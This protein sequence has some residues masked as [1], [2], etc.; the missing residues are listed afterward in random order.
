MK[1][2]TNTTP[3]ISLAAIGKF[4]LFQQL[5]ETII[6]PQA[7]HDEIKVKQSFAYKEIDADWVQVK[8]VE[9]E[10]Y[11]Q[12]LRNDLDQGEAE[13]ICL[14]K[15]IAADALIIDERMGYKIAQSQGFFV[16]G[17]LTVLA[18]AKKAELIEQVKPL[19]KDLIEAGRWYS[20][21]V[22]K[23]FLQKIGEIP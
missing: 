1:I 12:L 20:P 23:D 2:V 18:M 4:S 17:S 15:E 7:V 19:L 10:L 14:A 5:F 6:I 3:L 16:I 21:A 9:D 13:C 22:Y 11:C 8:Q